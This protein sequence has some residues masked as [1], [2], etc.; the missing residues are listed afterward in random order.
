M[1]EEQPAAPAA[2]EK[3]AAPA[4]PATPAAAPAEPEKKG[5]WPDGWQ[6]RLAGD[7]PD[8]LKQIGRYASPEEIWKKAKSLER[9]LSSGELKAV[10]PKDPKPEDVS[11]WRKDNGIPES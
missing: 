4:Q 7:D 10:L 2:P 8:A 5:Y 3:P 11:A 1:A 9:R 6:A